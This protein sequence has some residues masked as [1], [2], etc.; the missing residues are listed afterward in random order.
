MKHDMRYLNTKNFNHQTRQYI[1][2]I[3]LPIYIKKNCHQQHNVKEKEI[4]H[5]LH[6]GR[7]KSS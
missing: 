3:Y 4:S 6:I 1:S 7:V 2:K 5:D